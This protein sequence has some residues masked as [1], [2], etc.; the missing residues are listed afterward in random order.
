MKRL[1]WL[2]IA[3]AVLVIPLIAAYAIDR[4]LL[5]PSCPDCHEEQTKA[6]KLF[7]PE[8]EG[9]VRIRASGL[10]F[11]AR[12]AG[13]E[14]NPDGE[15]VVLLHGFAAT[16]IMWEPLT[17]KLAGQGYRVVAFDQ[18]GY[19]PGANPSRVNAYTSGRLA[20]DVIAIAAAVGFD[21]LHVVGHDFGGAIAW[22]AADHFPH[23]V[24]SVAS[25]STPHPA[26]LAEALETPGAQWAHSSYVLFYRMP[27]L[28]EL[29]LGFNG[30]S[31]LQNRIWQW[32]PEEHVEEYRRVFAGPGALHGPLNWY[33]AFEFNSHDPLGKITQPSL[34]L[35]G[36]EDGAF[37]HVAANKTANYVEG[38][39]RNHSLR[40]GH[41]LMV[42]VP[43]QVTDAVL[44]HLKTWSQ[45]SKQWSMVSSSHQDDAAACDQPRPHCLNILV[46]P[47]GKS[48]RIRN[49]CDQRH[50]GTVRI[51]CTGWAPEAFVEFRFD[52]GPKGHMAQRNNGFS[53]GECY[54]RHLLCASQTE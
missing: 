12:V 32:L 16:S 2:W 49:K 18:R 19:S 21:R 34:Y 11:R 9:L 36:T 10:E 48:M 47:D 6:L 30:A 40:A 29:V 22:T 15:G 14:E 39:Y 54:Y 38:P 17:E 31:Y 46:A 44:S 26:A 20:A 4:L 3:W 13:F 51:S 8:S 1:K 37:G 43:D 45:T 27:W 24:M 41:N 28:P 23:E 42:E 25:L 7:T 5:A 35:W 52:L 50:K 53:A 33:R